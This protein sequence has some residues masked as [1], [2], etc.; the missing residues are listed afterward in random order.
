M[1]I[2]FTICGRAGS[3][4]L[5]GKNLSLLQSIPLA[6]FTLS[7][8]LLYEKKYAHKIDIVLSSDSSQLHELLNTNGII[9][10]NRPANLSGDNVSKLPVIKHAYETASLI[11]KTNYELIVDLDITSPI[12]RLSDLEEI[13][14]IYQ[15]NSF[16]L[17]YTVTNARRNPYFN[18][19]EFK[20][21]GNIDRVIPSNYVT[22]QECPIVYDMNASI[23]CYSPKYLKQNHEMNGEMKKGISFMK[24]SLILDIDSDDDLKTLN[25]L[26]PFFLENEKEFKDIYLN[27]KNIK[28]SH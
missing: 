28:S 21:N 11:R 23:Y 2:L 20:N 14:N 24:D 16:D 1:N 26:V 5:P 7:L 13:I 22:R 8:I 10:I 3:K 19:V 12:R 6:Y 9:H 18:M 25:H 27:A 17:V 4:G 15:S